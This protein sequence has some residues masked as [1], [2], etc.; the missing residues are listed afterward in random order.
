[1]SDETLY[2]IEIGGQEYIDLAVAADYGNGSLVYQDY[3]ARKQGDRMVVIVFS[4]VD[5]SEAY[6]ND[7]L[8]AFTTY[9]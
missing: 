1:M 8:N 4:Y 2:L 3:C 6:L 7:A 5:G 9:E